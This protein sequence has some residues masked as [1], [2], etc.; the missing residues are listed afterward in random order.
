MYAKNSD[1]TQT[2]SKLKKGTEDKKA[3]IRATFKNRETL[4]EPIDIERFVI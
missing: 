2:L 3:G 1:T 4:L